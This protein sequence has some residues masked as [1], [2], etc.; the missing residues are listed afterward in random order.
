[1]KRGFN[2]QTGEI[3]DVLKALSQNGFAQMDIDSEREVAQIANDLA[4]LDGKY[5]NYRQKFVIDGMSQ[6]E[7]F[8][9]RIVF[10]CGHYIDLFFVDDEP[11]DYDEIFW[12]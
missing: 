1:M 5:K 4:K 6:D 11:E 2:F 10:E 12:G 8:H 3:K 9:S 7:Q